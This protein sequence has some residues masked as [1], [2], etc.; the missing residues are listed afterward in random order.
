MRA[1]LKALMP[2]RS[3]FQPHAGTDGLHTRQL[4]YYHLAMAVVLSAALLASLNFHHNIETF[5]YDARVYWVMAAMPTHVPVNDLIRGYFF[6][7]F[8]RQV[9]LVFY[10]LGFSPLDSLKL[11]FSLVYALGLTV[12]L[13]LTYRR[14]KGQSS[15]KTPINL[16][17][18]LLPTILMLIIFPGLVIYPL[19]DLPAVLLTWLAI[20]W[21]LCCRDLSD[22]RY[23]TACRVAL[24]VL[25]GL[26]LGL[27]YNTRTVFL[28]AVLLVLL[29]AWLQFRGRRHHVLYMVLGFAL[30]C[31]PQVL[32]NR[33]HH[34][35]TSI[36][37]SAIF[38]G[39]S[40]FAQQLTWGL[41]VQRYETAVANKSQPLRPKLPGLVYADPQGQQLVDKLLAAVPHQA[42]G[43][44]TV[45]LTVNTVADYLVIVLQ[46]PLEFAALYTRHLV[47]GLNVRDGMMYITYD[48]SEN[49]AIGWLS[50]T[51]L[52]LSLLAMKASR[53]LTVAGHVSGTDRGNPWLQSNSLYA[54]ALITPSLIAIPGAMETRFMLPLLL[55]GW[56]AIAANWSGP[57]VW[58]ELRQYRWLYASIVV[59]V[60]ISVFFII[61]NTAA[62]LQ[63]PW[64]PI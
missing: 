54:L 9:S 7:W 45:T 33:H 53:R 55:Y 17:R 42:G 47:N 22:H 27:A 37:P 24:A 20:Y 50:I 49:A 52:L 40:L 28:F 25:A 13:P 23:L 10:G 1:T 19:S 32:M 3:L 2:S 57:A 39:K 59:T 38:V 35:I 51:T 58:A 11:Y 62:N 63:S 14:L 16:P 41:T 21:V 43:G 6:P 64:L 56:V 4:P 15:L 18:A 48:S 12:L 36:N 61:E 8:M 30:S 44:N 26:A 31:I 5:F 46:H 60:Y 29:T 34:G